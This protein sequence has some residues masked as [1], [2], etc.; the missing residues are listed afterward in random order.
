MRLPRCGLCSCLAAVLSVW[1]LGSVAGCR[2]TSAAGKPVQPDPGTWVVFQVVERGTGQPLWSVVWADGHQEDFETLDGETSTE[3]RFEGLGRVADGFAV[4]FEPR[5]PLK[6]LAWAPGH[7]LAVQEL[8]PERGE[9]RV[10]FELR[11]VEIEDERVPEEIR[12]EVPRF[13]PSEGPR[14]GS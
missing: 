8:V 5:Q 2:H 3:V 11:K 10:Q 6:L 12:L 13:Q 9:N 7:E 4:P 1:I 14:T